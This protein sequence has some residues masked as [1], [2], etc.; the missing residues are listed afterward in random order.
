M[1]KGGYTYIMSNRKRTVFYIGVTNHLFTRIQQ[2]RSNE[3]SKFCSKYNCFDL[4]YYE[5]YENINDAI[6]R[7]KQL[8]RWH[9][10]WKIN[11]IKEMNP[12]LLDLSSEI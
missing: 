6:D 2:H 1:I 4:V 3:G 10:K 12:E 5:T 9:R 8:K 11:L 7:E